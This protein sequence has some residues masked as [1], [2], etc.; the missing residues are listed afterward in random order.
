VDKA[1]NLRKAFFLLVL[2]AFGFLSACGNESPVTIPPVPAE[3]PSEPPAASPPV[4]ALSPANR[5]DIVYFHPKV[6]CAACISVELRTQA[7]IN[8]YFKDAR[9]SGKLT[10]QDY[11]LQDK[12]NATMVKK[13]G[14][15]GSQLFIT[16]VKN[17]V[18]NIKHIEEVWMPQI[19]NDQVAF[20]E[21]MHK[22]ISQ[23]LKEVA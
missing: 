8:D 6:R 19:L 4:D 10:F 22:L 15:L 23:S 18:E 14:A 13:Y 12:Q 9:D 11:E 20:D 1:I 7:V 16:T 3:K 2:L 5:V 17:G 21:F